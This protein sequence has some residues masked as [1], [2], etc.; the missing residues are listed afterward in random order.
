MPMPP[1]GAAKP[2]L[3]ASK[4]DIG[5][6]VDFQV[7]DDAADRADRLDEAPERAEQS[8]EDEQAGQVAGNVARLVEPRR[9]RVEEGAHGL[10]RDGDSVGPLAA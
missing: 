7:V 1:S 10:R 2:S 9:Q 3:S 5:V 6:A 4:T 8:E